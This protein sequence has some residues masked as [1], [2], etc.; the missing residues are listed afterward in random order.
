MAR[1]IILI[2]GAPTVGKSTLARALATELDLPWIST[3]TIR[4]MMLKLSGREEGSVPGRS[5]PMTAEEYLTTYSAREIVERQN[6]ESEE[7]WAFVRALIDTDDTWGSFIVEGV[8]I[9][10]HLVARDYGGNEEIKSIFL[11]TGS[12][13]RIRRV[14]FTRGLYASAHEYSDMVKGKEVE[15]VQLLSAWLK[16]E[17]EAYGYTWF[18]AE[19][20]TTD[21]VLLVEML[22]LDK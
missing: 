16:G 18:E 7:V 8:A 9:L 20:D 15:W 22:S 12:A 19:G 5:S 14:V 17:A 1:Q 4:G 21:F 2:G 10:P 6:R 13:D 3:D 11:V